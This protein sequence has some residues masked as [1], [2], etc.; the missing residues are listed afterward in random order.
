MLPQENAATRTKTAR[1]PSLLNT[2]DDS[3]SPLRLHTVKETKPVERHILYVATDPDKK[4]D[5][6]VGCHDRPCF[7]IWILVNLLVVGVAYLGYSAG[8]LGVILYP[9]DSLGNQ[10]GIDFPL[11]KSLFYFNVSATSSYKRCVDYCPPGQAAV[12]KYAARRLTPRYNTTAS[13]NATVWATQ[14]NNGSCVVAQ[15]STEAFFR[16]I[17]LSVT[18]TTSFLTADQLVASQVLQSDFQSQTSMSRLFNKL[19]AGS[20][21]ILIC[22]A[23]S[24]AASIL[25]YYLLLVFGTSLLYASFSLFLFIL[26]GLACYFIYTY[27]L[28]Y[29]IQSFASVLG[30]ILVQSILYSREAIMAGMIASIVI[31]VLTCATAFVYRNSIRL[32]GKIVHEAGSN[33]LRLWFVP[34]IGICLCLLALFV[35][36]SSV[37][38]TGWM[39]TISSASGMSPLLTSRAAINGYIA[40]IAVYFVWNLD[41][42]YAFG[43]MVIAR[44]V[45]KVYW[46]SKKNCSKY[47]VFSSSRTILR[48][49]LGSIALGVVA[50]PI[51]VVANFIEYSIRPSFQ[52]AQIVD[53]VEVVIG[54]DT[55]F[56]RARKYTARL[57]ATVNATGFVQMALHGGSFFEACV[58]TP[59]VIQPGLGGISKMGSIITWICITSV[60]AVVV[61]VAIVL[62][63][64]TNFTIDSDLPMIVIVGMIALLV[65]SIILQV[66]AMAVETILYCYSEDLDLHDG[67]PSNPY[68]MSESLQRFLREVQEKPKEVKKKRPHKEKSSN[69]IAMVEMSSPTK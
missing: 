45:S 69:S 19:F 24:I 3:I 6:K 37:L 5:A 35:V 2:Q 66:F 30:V 16:C 32:A 9:Y 28:V 39:F 68:V 42:I 27:L 38:L 14:V 1:K 29:V 65:S 26:F 20:V 11:Q 31:F 60:T 59:D 62:T 10:C 22:S 21:T 53:E 67:T 63:T 51:N 15:K 36:F 7:L 17:P 56:D 41:I 12:C 44:S 55:V 54:T 40:I 46:A 52:K 25:W 47:W 23:V 50:V 49:H 43:R 33:L 8:N 64:N 18:S 34:V 4:E 13:T 58:V 61:V 57:L 48:Y